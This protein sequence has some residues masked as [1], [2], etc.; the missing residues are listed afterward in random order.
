[1][2][3]TARLLAFI[4]FVFV[5]ALVVYQEIQSRRGDEEEAP[6]GKVVTL[7]SHRLMFPIISVLL[8][9]SGAAAVVSLV[10]AGHEGAKVTW[11]NIDRK[12]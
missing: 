9:I 3:D 7:A 4:F 11:Q 2:G 6:A 5:A 8:V 12:P 10:M 1:M